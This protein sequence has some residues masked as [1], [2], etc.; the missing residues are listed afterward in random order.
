M[1]F[2]H[3]EMASFLAI[4]LEK[5]LWRLGWR[6]GL[7]GCLT[8][9]GCRQESCLPL[10]GTCGSAGGQGDLPLVGLGPPTL[11]SRSNTGVGWERS[12]GSSDVADESL[13]HSDDAFLQKR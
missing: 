6:R 7:W 12:V 13:V 8:E 2:L 11:N 10:A 9:R 3:S 5:V 4:S 1:G